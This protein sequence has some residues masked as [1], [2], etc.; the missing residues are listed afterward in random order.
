MA[1]I[2][3]QVKI[4]KLHYSGCKPHGGLYLF[5]QQPTLFFTR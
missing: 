5:Y 1:V 4:A 2:C 3:L